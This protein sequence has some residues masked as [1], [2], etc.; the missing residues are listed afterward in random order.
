MRVAN[1]ITL[2]DD[3]RETLER[4]ARS[5]MT[6]VRLVERA[7]IILWASEGRMS[8]WIAAEL[9]VDRQTVARWR[10]RFVAGGLQAIQF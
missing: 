8:K 9:Q 4:R 3:E 1:R 2:T 5:R 6:P 7:K 10:K